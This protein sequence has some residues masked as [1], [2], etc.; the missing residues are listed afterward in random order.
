LNGG[1]ETL[2]EAEFLQHAV[3]GFDFAGVRNFFLGYAGF[4]PISFGGFIGTPTATSAS[5]ILVEGGTF[6]QPVE[7]GLDAGSSLINVFVFG[8]ATVCS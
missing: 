3:P 8:N 4:R 7:I 2:T 1:A 6:Q 5:F